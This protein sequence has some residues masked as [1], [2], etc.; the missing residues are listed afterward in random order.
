MDLRQQISTCG[1]TGD[2]TINEAILAQASSTEFALK[3]VTDI[4]ISSDY[5]AISEAL[6]FIRDVVLGTRLPLA[7]AFAAKLYTSSVLS[8]IEHL[9]FCNNH[10]TRGLAVYTLG[11]IYSYNSL[12]ILWQAFQRFKESDPLLIPKIAFEIAWLEKNNDRYWWNLINEA[13][14]NQS[15]L[16]RWSVVDIFYHNGMGDAGYLQKIAPYFD[17]LRHDENQFVRAE[18]EFVYQDLVFFLKSKR[19]SKS[20]KQVRSQ[21]IDQLEPKL[22]FTTLETRFHNHLCSSEHRDYRLEQLEQFVEQL[23]SG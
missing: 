18:A 17:A 14:Q 20:R 6:I 9:V 8:A 23:P 16:T 1:G 2:K 12:E 5:N 3:T 11:K 15:Y 19:W 4:L 21:E 7:E 13:Y 22:T 10:F